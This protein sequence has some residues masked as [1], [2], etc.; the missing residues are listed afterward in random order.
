MSL[1]LFA[2]VA[3]LVTASLAAHADTIS[4]FDASGT[5]DDGAT[6][7]GTIAFDVTTGQP[8][9]SD[10]L[11]LTVSS[12]ISMIYSSPS[13][14]GGGSILWESSDLSTYLRLLIGPTNFVGYTGG[15][16]SSESDPRSNGNVSP[17]GMTTILS[18]DYPTTNLLV[19]TLT[20]GELTLESSTTTT[21]EPSSIALLGTGL[22][23]VAGVVRRRLVVF[24]SR[25]SL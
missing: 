4:V 1:R 17:V 12:P 2:V 15:A 14:G 13:I 19:T 25:P 3:A 11:Y 16:L 23:C 7:S 21:P 8:I 22:L 18:N 20:E 5:F 10:S 9:E 24:K 6:L